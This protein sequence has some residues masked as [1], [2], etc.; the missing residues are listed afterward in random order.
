M[1][2][3]L[4]LLLMVTGL[5]VRAQNCVPNTSCLQF[6]GTSTYV[7]LN[8]NNNLSITDS[9][10]I[11]AWINS[12]AWGTTSAKN[13]IVCKHGWYVG[14]E[15]YTFRCG[16]TGELSFNI[17]CD[18]AGTNVSWRELISHNAVLQLNH[19]HHVACSFTGTELRLYIDGVLDTTRVFGAPVS[20]IASPDYSL[21]IGKLADDNQSDTRFFS[22]KI[23]EVRIWHLILDQSEIAANMSHHIDPATAVGLV[24]YYRMNENTG[25][26]LTDLGTGA[27]SGTINNGTWSTTVP[28]TEGPPQPYITISSGYLLNSSSTSAN[29]WNL[30]GSP[31]PGE[32]AVSY[33]PTQNGSYT[34]TVTDSNGCSATSTQ[35]LVTTLGIDKPESSIRFLESNNVNGILKFA[36]PESSLTKSELHIFDSAGKESLYL[37]KGKITKELAIDLS[38]GVYFVTLTN[39]SSNYREKIIVR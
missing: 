29:Q 14:E 34:V 30:N 31:I 9:I 3:K 11:E 13:S 24:G 33:Q 28:F 2:S 16:G 20:I 37:G 12:N 10:T 15:G 8:S 22:G 21:K 18:S 32:T 6:D 7:S 26:S 4:L 35:V 39:E 36:M 17:A 23:D 27:N 19:W 38:A 25:A 1:K 5:G